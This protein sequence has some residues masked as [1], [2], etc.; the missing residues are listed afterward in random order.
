M[1]TPG[2][3]SIYLPQPL[4]TR[5]RDI[6]ERERRQ[7]I[8]VV[9]RMLDLYEPLTLG[10]HAILQMAAQDQG[11]STG[12]ALSNILHDWN[13]SRKACGVQEIAEWQCML[14]AIR[15]NREGRLSDDDLDDALARITAPE[16]AP[17]P[18]EV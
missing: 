2:S 5:V 16:R 12:Q 7:I 11:V 3:T 9:E 4:A 13:E 1:P 6:A 15:A 17:L 8:D 18:V 14:T 10:D